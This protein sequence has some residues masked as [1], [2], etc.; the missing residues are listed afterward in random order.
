M[1]SSN[2]ASGLGIGGVTGASII[3]AEVVVT[4]STR[5]PLEVACGI[6]AFVCTMVWWLGRKFQSVDDRLEIMDSKLNQ[7]YCVREK[8]NQCEMRK[9]V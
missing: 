7:L 8:Q 5:V 9:D 1:T 3:I 4:G 2:I 6:G